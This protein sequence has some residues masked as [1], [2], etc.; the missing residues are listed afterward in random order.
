MNSTITSG[1]RIWKETK[2]LLK[3]MLATEKGEFEWFVRIVQI[4]DGD[5]SIVAA[6]PVQPYFHLYSKHSKPEIAKMKKQVIE[7]VKKNLKTYIK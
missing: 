2:F 7:Y 4:N 3:I 5:Y 6:T 1:S